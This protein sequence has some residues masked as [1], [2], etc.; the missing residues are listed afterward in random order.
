MR[1]SKQKGFV[2]MSKCEYQNVRVCLGESNTKK[3]CPHI[4]DC[5]LCIGFSIDKNGNEVYVRGMAIEKKCKRD[6]FYGI[7]D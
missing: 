5:D 3:P 2:F 4:D 7:G 6:G 1:G